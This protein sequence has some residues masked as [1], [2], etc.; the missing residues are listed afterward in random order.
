MKNDWTELSDVTIPLT[1]KGSGP[2]NDGRWRS[3]GLFSWRDIIPCF[4]SPSIL[5]RGLYNLQRNGL[6]RFCFLSNKRRLRRRCWSSGT[7]FNRSIPSSMGPRCIFCMQNVSRREEGESNGREDGRPA[8]PSKLIGKWWIG[9][10]NWPYR[11][12]WFIYQKW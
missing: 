6:K 12:H 3:H 11:V 8:W 7:D 5:N 2:E 10:S 4:W 9:G 1:W